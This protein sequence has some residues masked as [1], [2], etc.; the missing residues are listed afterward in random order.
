MERRIARMVAAGLLLGWPP[1]VAADEPPA[2]ARR[3]EE[4]VVT[5]EREHG[6]FPSEVEHATI[7]AGKKA[8]VTD[9]NTLPE[10]QSNN[11]RQTFSQ[12]PGLLIAEQAVPSHANINYRGIGDPHETNFLLTLKDGI[13]I[14]SDW[15]GYSTLYYQ[16]PTE[17]IERV[18]L[19]R[20]GGSLLYGPQPGPALNFVTRQPPEEPFTA[21]TDH[22]LGS[23]GLYNTYNAFGGTSGSLGYRG[24][25]TRRHADGARPNADYTVYN[26]NAKAVL[27]TDPSSQWAFNVDAYE[28]ESGEAGRLSLSQYLANRDFARTPSDRIWIER[29]APSVS[30]EHDLS[31]ETLLVSKG[32]MGYQDR[33]SRRQTGTATNLDRQE[34][35]FAGL[36]MRLRHTWQAWD[37]EHTTTGGFVLYGSDSPRSRKRG[38]EPKATTGPTRFELD[39]RTLY[40]ALFAE[41]LLKLNRLS[42]VPAFRLEL[43]DMKVQELSNVEVTRNLLK[44]SYT[45]VV[46]LGAVG[47]AYD[48]GQGHAWY[49]NIAQGYRPKQYDD[50][51]NPTSNTQ[52]ASSASGLEESRTLTYETGVRGTPAPWVAYDTSLFLVDYRDYIETLTLSGGNT[53]RSNSG[54]ARFQGWEGA[55]EMD[56]VGLADRLATTSH[57]DRWGRLSLYNSLSLL[58]AEFLN[59]ANEGRDPAYAPKY[60]VKTGAVYRWRDRAKVALLGQYVGNHFWQDS[61]AASTVG[62]TKVASYKVW[63]LTSDVTLSHNW[64]LIAGVNNLFD[65]DYYSRIR[66]DGIEPAPRRT[67]YLGASLSF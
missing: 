9:L 33:F 36:D 8:T 7:Y 54:R 65:E 35:S 17:D 44:D 19:I 25:F 12:M 66:S 50:L 67:Y 14:V 21:R 10:I 27:K 55:I 1:L 22:V 32:W 24:S 56:L 47:L 31:D 62:T 3:M 30:Y 51:V 58:E 59:G 46:P 37:N 5:A 40:G 15:F 39:R 28:S 57:G 34:F 38:S 4:V 11:Y 41:Q 6:P 23:D 16:P 42:V 52:L 29:Y 13:P 49:G 64:R 2:D 60:M 45:D 63:D 18:E 20:G 48:L 61:N 26:G 53:E 43:I